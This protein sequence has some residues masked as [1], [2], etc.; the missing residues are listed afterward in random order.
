MG[1]PLMREALAR[2]RALREEYELVLEAHI[3][4]A[5]EA[6]RGNMVSDRGVRELFM[7]GEAYANAYASDE[8]KEFWLTHPRPTFEDYLEARGY[9]LGEF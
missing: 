2:R 7:H 4:A 6:T 5:E 8:L 1:D 9:G 3:D